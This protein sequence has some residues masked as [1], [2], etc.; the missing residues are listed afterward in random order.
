MKKIIFLLII[1]LTELNAKAQMY[2]EWSFYYTFTVDNKVR[3]HFKMDSLNVYVS[4]PFNSSEFRNG[5]LFK[6]DTTGL[7]DVQLN[8]GSMRLQEL[9]PS[10]FHQHYL[11]KYL[12]VHWN[13]EVISH[14]HC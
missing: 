1:L 13:T 11:F 4:C 9:R 6:N 10:V 5:S 8:Y 12:C 2:F 3:H 7:Y 14:F